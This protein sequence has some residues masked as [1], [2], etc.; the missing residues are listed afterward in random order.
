MKINAAAI[1]SAFA[2]LLPLLN[3]AAAQSVIH[4][5]KDHHRKGPLRAPTIHHEKLSSEVIHH[6]K[7]SHKLS[8]QPSHNVANDD[9][10]KRD[11]FELVHFLAMNANKGP[12]KNDFNGYDWRHGEKVTEERQP[13][14][15]ESTSWESFSPACLK[16][17]KALIT[18]LDRSYTDE[19]LRTV[20][21]HDCWLDKEFNDDYEDG[22]DNHTACTQFAENLMVAREVEVLHGTQSGY[23]TFCMEY[24]LY[25]GGKM[26]QEQEQEVDVQQKKEI[27]VGIRISWF[28]VMVIVMQC[29]AAAGIWMICKGKAT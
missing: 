24:F 23:E 21:T 1:R 9:K 5:T 2:L 14:P 13:K 27:P 22:F 28:I 3:L 7:P 19:Q 16:H 18:D 26:A 25:K 12:P 20:L 15:M 29:I 10:V 11:V 17:T 4:H 8:H 6:E